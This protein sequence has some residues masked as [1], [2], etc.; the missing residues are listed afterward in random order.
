VSEEV[1]SAINDVNNMTHYELARL[2]RF[3]TSDHLYI[4]TPAIFDAVMNRLFEHF[5]GITPSISKQ[6]GWEE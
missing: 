2:W 1:Q 6:V 5:G 3:G 4:K